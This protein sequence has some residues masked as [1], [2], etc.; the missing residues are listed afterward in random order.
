MHLTVRCL[1]FLVQVLGFQHIYC[2]PLLARRGFWSSSAEAT[3]SPPIP[4]TTPRTT[5]APTIPSK[6]DPAQA[7]PPQIA[8]YVGLEGLYNQFKDVNENTKRNTIGT[9]F[10]IGTNTAA[11]G[12]NLANELAKLTRSAMNSYMDSQSRFLD[13]LINANQAIEASSHQILNGTHQA[14]KNTL[15]YETHNWDLMTD[16]YT[17]GAKNAINS[18][19]G[20]SSSINIKTTI[21]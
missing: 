6:P 19:G 18:E 3:T 15:D 12:T 14:I 16:M 11:F 9:A 17:T 20:G 21:G 1:I 13:S 2:S 8:K 4:P 7:P 5:R 10:T